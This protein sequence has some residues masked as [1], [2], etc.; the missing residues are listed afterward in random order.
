MI[1]NLITKATD[2]L[3][4]KI[5]LLKEMVNMQESPNFFFLLSSLPA[6]P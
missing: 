6:F 4:N 5:K 1:Q 2:P 3:K